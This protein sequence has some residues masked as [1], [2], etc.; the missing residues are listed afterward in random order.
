MTIA[1]G[2]HFDGGVLMCSDTELTGPGLTIQDTK[3]STFACPWGKLA[4]TYCGNSAFAATATRRIE[5]HLSTVQPEQ[6]ENELH[7]LADREYRR[8]VLTNPARVRDPSAWYRLLIAVCGGGMCDLYASYECGLFPVKVYDF[9]GA[10]AD[11]AHYLIRPHYLY[12]MQE[13]SALSLGAF[14]L[15][16]IKDYVDGCG[17]ISQFVILRKDGATKQSFAMVRVGFPIREREDWIEAHGRQYE[18]TARDLF[19]ALVDTGIMNA[20]FDRKADDFA[21]GLKQLRAEVFKLPA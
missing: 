18:K 20:D 3:I 19:F 17:G 8:L 5:R 10:G 16:A 15:G 1:A 11:L 7:K 12:G 14:M 9:I 21:A 2:F 4:T 13:G 6:I